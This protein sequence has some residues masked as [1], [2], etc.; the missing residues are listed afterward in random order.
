MARELEAAALE[1]LRSSPWAAPAHWPRVVLVREPSGALRVER[2]A[3]IART[4]QRNGDRQ[5]AIEIANRV[6]PPGHVLLVEDAGGAVRLELVD[7]RG[8]RR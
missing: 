3:W 8:L 1:A 7:L 2:R 6:V 5:A 4:V